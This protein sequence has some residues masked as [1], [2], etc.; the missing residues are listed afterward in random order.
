MKSEK[1]FHDTVTTN[2]TFIG[3]RTNAEISHPTFERLLHMLE[4]RGWEV[5][6]DQQVLQMY[7]NISADYFEG[8]KG[9]L[10]RTSVV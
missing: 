4:G 9:D 10:D 5:Q 8:K 3:V 6:I 7:P 2:G 1:V